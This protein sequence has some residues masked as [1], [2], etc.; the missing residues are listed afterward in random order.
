MIE[1]Q[2]NYET[3]YLEYLEVLRN[4]KNE[5][6]FIDIIDTFET[7]EEKIGNLSDFLLEDGIHLSKKGHEIYFETISTSLSKKLLP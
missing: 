2:C 4:L 1:G 7:F 3:N 6:N 5:L